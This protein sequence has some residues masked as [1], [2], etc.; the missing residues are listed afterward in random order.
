M[1]RPSAEELYQL[2]TFARFLQ[3]GR[4][5]HRHDEEKKENIEDLFLR[6]PE[7]IR[8]SKF[9]PTSSIHQ[10]SGLLQEQVAVVFHLRVRH[11]SGAGPS[12][13]PRRR[14]R[15]NEI[16]KFYNFL[17]TFGG[18]VLGCIKTN[19]LAGRSVRALREV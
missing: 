12:A 8:D 13:E 11:G 9:E 18:L 17:Q 10:R 3:T 16:G 1:H 19:D 5:A 14:G 6:A 15:L 2:Q 7:D 4:P